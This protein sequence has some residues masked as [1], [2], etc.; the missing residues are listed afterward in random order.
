VLWWTSTESG[1]LPWT[2]AP[3]RLRSSVAAAMLVAGA[4]LRARPGR[5]A[6]VLVGVAAATAMLVGVF[7]GSLIARERA[8]QRAVARLPS[9]ERSFNVDLV[10]LPTQQRYARMDRTASAAL[11]ALS[12]TEPLR[13]G[14]FRDFWLDGEFVRLVGIDRL[15][16]YVRLRSGRLPRSCRPDACEVLQI[17]EQ[18]RRVLREGGIH[19]V[20]VGTAELRDVAAFGPTFEGLRQYRAQTS[21]VRST[22][23]L[24]RDSA[25]FERLPALQFLQR[26]RSWIVPINPSAIHSWQIESLLQRESR[27]QTRL[28]Q[29]DPSFTLSGPDAALLEARDRGQISGQR[30]VLIGGG[31]SAL[32]LGFAIV[33]AVGLRR[34]LASE[35]RRLLQRGATRA[36]VWLAFLSEIGAVTLAGW[37]AGITFGVLA[38]A[39]LANRLGLP[40][41]AVIAY[42]LLQA[43]A[44]LLLVAAWMAATAVVVATALAREEHAVRRGRRLRLLDVAALGAVL[45]LVVGL[46]RGGLSADALASGGDRT[47]LLLLP[48]LLCLI[49]AV[50]AAR[51]LGPL[52]RLGE[53]LSRR[54]PTALRLALLALGRA[55][56]RTALA[57]AFLVVSVGLALFAATYRATLERGAQDEAG[58]AVPFDLSLTEGTKLAQPLDVASLHRYEQLAANVRAYPILRRSADVPSLGTSAQGVTVLGIPA[59]G[60]EGMYWRSDFAPVPRSRLTRALTRDGPATLRGPVLPAAAVAFR[61]HVRLRGTAIELAIALQ[62]ASGRIRVVSLGRVERGA[63]TLTAPVDRRF[64]EGRLRIVALEVDLPN[65]ERNWLFHLANEGRA[66]RAPA[67][68]VRLGPLTTADSV[69]R[70]QTHIHWRGWVARGGGTVG[71]AGGK[72]RL[73]YAF[74]DVRTILLRPREP[75]D[76]RPLPIV[77]SPGVAR[78]AGAGGLLTLDFLEP[79]IRARVI[80][81]ATRFP[82]LQPDEPFV[83]AEETQLATALDADAPGRGRPDELWLS[84]P[85]GALPTLQS[86]LARPPFAALERT[87]RRRTLRALEDDP[88]AHAIEYTLGIAA[89]LALALAL[90][91]LWVTLLSD[92]CD[93]RS[94]F[95]DLEA[96]GVTPATLRRHLRIRA[97]VLLGFGMLGGA[98]LGFVLARLVVS[99]IQVSAETGSPQPPLVFN[100]SWIACALV[101]GVLALA[102]AAGAEASTRRAFR[103]AAP[104]RASRGLE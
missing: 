71:A 87:S 21:L 66:V 56:A 26:A 102:A 88:M 85:G 78:A 77:A 82:T 3:R 37:L 1:V 61:V 60:L 18:G 4:R 83:V 104:Q 31:G 6:L 17:G 40:A 10:G 94:D 36:Q 44:I 92:L 16:D 5:T 73:S 22:V 67:G 64:G 55:P 28:A 93:E 74:P 65:N 11:S 34:G 12:P 39:V 58:F 86:A 89:L 51:L 63:T 54:A 52:M 101:L 35:R 42:S 96:Q 45:A 46:T 43:E 29:A 8:L 2:Q 98:L 30:L 9:G 79:P 48:G 91:G 19:L 75:S 32:L 68:S 25:S 53:R 103:G 81:I 62:D 69:G 13:V 95:F 59:Q 57:G 49:A 38:V 99:L 24:P 20:R 100:P 90:I 84:A 47:L 72:T 27:V 80:G 7:G 97:L 70:V 41:G 15:R 76:G 14:F 23:L 50:V 33:A